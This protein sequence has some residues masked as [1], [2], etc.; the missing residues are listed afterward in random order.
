MRVLE[1]DSGNEY[2]AKLARAPKQSADVSDGF[3]VRLET[4]RDPEQLEGPPEDWASD[5][6]F[7]TGESE[8][9]VDVSV[10][11]SREL[12]AALATD[13]TERDP[14]AGAD[15]ERR[16]TGHGGAS[17][18]LPMEGSAEPT[19]RRVEPTA[20]REPARPPR[21]SPPEVESEALFPEHPKPQK[22]RTGRGALLVAA[23]AVSS[24]S[25][26]AAWT[27]FAAP[28]PEGPPPQAK[29]DPVVVVNEAGEV[30]RPAPQDD[31]GAARSPD[32]TAI[33][34]RTPAS[35]N[36]AA[37]E[38]APRPRQERS[39]R[40]SRQSRAPSTEETTRAPSVTTRAPSPRSAGRLFLDTDPWTF[41][42]VG[43]RSLGQTPIVDEPLP[44]GE[45]TVELRES[46]G[47]VH[48]VRVRIAPDRSTKRFI[49]LR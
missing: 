17:L 47:E 3:R 41:V 1:L 16:A 18:L 23:L 5:S 40:E 33:A 26:A 43:E 22:R 7:T 21:A 28:E 15:D 34:Q 10:S 12:A 31:V 11:G 29:G 42:R 8:V 48:R 6:G 27:I 46:S 37:E 44:A 36:V 32:A 14:V 24:A 13:R 4:L 19:E 30:D 39:P 38:R 9:I 25:A 20:A 2:L 45:H 35:S 49:T